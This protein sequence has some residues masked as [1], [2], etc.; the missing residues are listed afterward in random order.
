[1]LD[2]SPTAQAY[3]SDFAL[4]T[5]GWKAFQDLCAQICH[6]SFGRTV[7]VYREAQDGGQDAVFLLPS[8]ATM[9]EATV[10][11]KFSSKADQRLRVSDIAEELDKVEALV[12]S[13]Y[14]SSYYFLTSFGVDAPVAGQIRDQL[15]HRG[16]KEP[17]VLGREW[18]ASEIKKSARLR[19]LVP[20]IYGLGDLSMIIDERSA[21]QTRALLAHLIPSLRVYVPTAAHRK[22]VRLL[23]EHKLVLLLGPP[24]VGKSM[25]AAILSTMAIDSNQLDCFK[26][27]GP[28]DLRQHWNP[29]EHRRL[30]WIDDAFGANQLRNDYI[31]TW[32]EFMPKMKAAIEQGNHFILTSR[33]HIWNEASVKLGTRKHPLLTHDRAVVSVGTLSPEERQQILYNHIKSGK[34]QH[35]WKKRV[36][37]FLSRLAED[38]GLV[39]EIARRLGDPSYT[40]ALRKFPS[41]LEN[42]LHH[43]QEFLEDTF[44]ELTVAQQAAMTLV[45]LMRSRLPV[46][47]TPEGECNLVADKYGTSV[48]G[49]VLA[50]DQLEGRFSSR[51]RMAVMNIG[52]FSIQP[53]PMP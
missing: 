33:T 7:S 14:A 43:P 17:H 34:Q 53:S 45:F 52:D 26:C 47:N 46:R 29:H 51:S 5:L 22:A 42:F 8:D 16:V 48:G 4:H 44:R 25:I 41:D 36:K 2:L 12:A 32:I 9:S 39:P 3:H 10:Q 30:F 11:C 20:R 28:L 24:A 21:S 38:P 18:I 19:A 49:I 27:D 31:N 1:M 40:K 37:P 35:D 13:G 6:E 50:L 15:R 23:G